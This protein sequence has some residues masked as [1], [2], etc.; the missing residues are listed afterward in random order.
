M[1]TRPD[2]SHGGKKSGCVCVI[3]DGGS[4][5]GSGP[6]LLA[7][8]PRFSLRTLR[9]EVGLINKMVQG[10]WRL[11]QKVGITAGCGEAAHSNSFMLSIW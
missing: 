3:A 8:F 2:R 7:L 10:E 5:L 4:Y 6:A 9:R 11:L 1:V